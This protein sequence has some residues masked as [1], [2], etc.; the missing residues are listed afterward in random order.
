MSVG[1]CLIYTSLAPT[2]AFAGDMEYVA[3]YAGES[4]ALVDEIKPATEI[5]LDLEREDEEVIEQMKEL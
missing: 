3:L 5:L 2:T 1:P 4:C